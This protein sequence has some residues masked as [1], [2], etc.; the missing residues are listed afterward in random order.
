MASKKRTDKSGKTLPWWE[1]PAV[2]MHEGASAWVSSCRKSLSRYHTDL[3]YY[4]S[5]FAGTTDLTGTGAMATSSAQDKLKYNL[6]SSVVET[7]QS[8]VGSARTL[9]YHLPRGGNWSTQR[10]AKK[11]TACLQAQFQDLGVF[12]RG[13]EVILDG[14]VGGLGTAHIFID[15]DT[16]LP[17]IE[18]VIP[19]ELSWDPNEALAGEVRTIARSKP[20]AR[21]VLIALYP[22][23]ADDIRKASGPSTLDMK[24]WALHRDGTADQVL[25]HEAW[26]L[27]PKQGGKGK[28]VIFTNNATLF[29]EEWKRPRFPFAFY[30]WAPRQ[31]GFIGKSLVAE[32]EPTQQRVEKLIRYIEVCQDL[33]SKPQ[34]WLEK[35]AEV[36]PQQIDNLPMSVNRYAGTP[37]VFQTFDATPHD[38]EASIDIMRER[39][40]NQLGLSM[41]AVSGEKPSGVS[42]AVAL[43]TVED[44]ASRRHVLNIRQVEAFYLDVAQC[45]A[46]ANDEVAADQADFKIDRRV[47]AR[48]L[49]STSWRECKIDEGDVRMTVYPISSLPPT[50]TGQ[51][52]RIEAWIQ[53]GFIQRDEAVM[54]LGMP[55]TE[56]FSDEVAADRTFVEWQIE[57]LLDGEKVLPEPMANLDM[58]A[59][60]VRRNYLIARQ[61]KADE[62][63]LNNFRVFL[64]RAKQMAQKAAEAAAPPP[65]AP[66]GP[67]PDLGLA[68][69]AAPAAQGVGLP[70]A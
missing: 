50:P 55:D 12:Q 18:R 44:I 25:V 35:G 65:A 52:E 54:L 17:G 64:G 10:K 69:Q 22:K 61:N 26:H 39:V 27:P 19:Q 68:A 11:R 32:V 33:G 34:V 60:V 37:P 30:R 23:H 63:V 2:D 42:S 41:S 66:G 29:C 59:D 8:I 57:R 47:K 14:C 9:P 24:D 46:D 31:V 7:A 4:M 45:L 20:V 51:L 21:E 43:Q 48:F 58:Q 62:A 3:L 28:H 49:D 56:A 1:Y 16:G 67:T 5:L 15:P 36:E 13:A 40:L 6:V 38:L 70:P 53:T